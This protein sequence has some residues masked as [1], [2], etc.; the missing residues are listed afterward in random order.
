M[1]RALDD[2]NTLGYSSYHQ[3]IMSTFSEQKNL[4]HQPLPSLQQTLQLL[5]QTLEPLAISPSELATT[6]NLI[7]KISNEP[8][9]QARQTW[10]ATQAQQNSSDNW[11]HDMWL[12]LAYHGSVNSP[13]PCLS[14]VCGYI[15]LEQERELT[16]S[17][18]AAAAIAGFLRFQHVIENELLPIQRDRKGNPLC[19][20][21]WSWIFGT[22]RLPS[23]SCDQL[24]QHKNSRHIVLFCRHFMYKLSYQDSDMKDCDAFEIL[25]AIQYILNDSKTRMQTETPPHISAL[26][27]WKRNEWCQA[28]TM[29]QSISIQNKQTL[30]DIETAAFVVALDTTTT[31]ASTATKLE[32]DSEQVRRNLHY[33]GEP[34]WFDKSFTVIINPI[35]QIGCNVEH[36][37]A[38][39]SVPLS[40]MSGPVALYVR[41]AYVQYRHRLDNN[42]STSTSTSTSST[43]SMLQ[44]LTALP[45]FNINATL[46]ENIKAATLQLHDQ[47]HDSDIAVARITKWTTSTLKKLKVSPD[48]TLQMSIQLA[49]YRLHHQ[50]VATYET[51]VLTK[52]YKGRT[53]TCRVAST[54]TSNFVQAMAKNNIDTETIQKLFLT[55]CQEHIQ[56]VQQASNGYGVDRHL[57]ALRAPLPKSMFQNAP[58]P[59]ESKLWTDPLFC[60][61]QKWL[62]STSNNSYLHDSGGHFGTGDPNGYGVGYFAR[63]NFI[64]YALESK[65]ST[66]GVGAAQKMS[67]A[68]VRALTDIHHLFNIEEEESKTTN[69]L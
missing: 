56:Y 27:G 18:S 25:A 11:L 55:A 36:S 23:K 8:S 30:S 12:F 45:S 69:R 63:N 67:D 16:Q 50:T 9:V 57:L 1:E 53:A 52:Y 3:I 32:S 21:Q 59:C 10:L 58:P 26:T 6:R 41:Q 34:R 62:L 64:C 42:F 7:E 39:A 14:N 65:R 38:E 31:E 19:M 46:F 48:S 22:T 13:L 37:W 68:C 33:I 4:P 49:Y 61:S 20:N 51:C 17:F 28:R 47:E 66:L 54:A 44:Q 2:D 40:I 43:S 5:L 29:L 15:H 35:G 24:I 60:R